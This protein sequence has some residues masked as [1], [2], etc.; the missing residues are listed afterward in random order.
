MFVGKDDT[1]ADSIDAQWTKDQ[2]GEPV[3]H[4]QLIEGGHF[5]FL[6]GKDMSYFT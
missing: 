6:I 1:I 5:T 2:I 4:Y 3:I